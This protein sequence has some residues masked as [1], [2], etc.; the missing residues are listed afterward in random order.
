MLCYSTVIGQALEL[1][2]SIFSIVKGVVRSVCDHGRQKGGRGKLCPWIL[3]FDI[4][5]LHSQQEK[6]VLLV[7]SG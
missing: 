4:F 2:V 1:I 5:L 6:N 7:S 3:K